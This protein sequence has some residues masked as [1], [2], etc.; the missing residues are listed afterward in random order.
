[1]IN[2][3]GETMTPEETLERKKPAVRKS[4]VIQDSSASP[5][6]RKVAVKKSAAK[7]QSGQTSIESEKK[8]GGL[9]KVILLMILAAL[10]SSGVTY[11][12]TSKSTTASPAVATSTFTE[13]IAGKVALTEPE[14]IAAV[15]QLGVDVYWAGPVKDA[16]YTLAVPADGQAY[17]R[18]LPNGQGIDDTKPNYV[19]IA[20]YTTTDAFT[21]TQAAGNSSNGVTFINT[22]GAAVY[23]NKDTPTNVYVAYPN[24]NYQIEV[25]DPIAATALDI[26]SRAGALKLV[27]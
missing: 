17:V 8:K 25:F 22:E 26:A 9:L 10:I 4:T 7:K 27:K 11:S 23:Y 13:V 14:L 3:E 5:R 15:K 24:L 1:M 21:A 12:I 2:N 18:Y 20:T 19:V 16:K 6:T